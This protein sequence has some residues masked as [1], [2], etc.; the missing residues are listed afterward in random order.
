MAKLSAEKKHDLLQ[1]VLSGRLDLEE[2]C[3]AQDVSL[4]E[5][6]KWASLVTTQSRLQALRRLADTRTQFLLSRYRAHAAARLIEL[7]GG[8]ESAETAR[9]ACVD[10]L[11]LN[12]TEA[13]GPDAETTEEKGTKRVRVDTER[14][15]SFLAELGRA[16]SGTGAAE[17]DDC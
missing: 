10:L 5:L 3:A 6:A 17:V 12:V 14:V 13:E 9:K 1:C 2:I 4:E 8:E 16:E 15:R 11:R 7:T